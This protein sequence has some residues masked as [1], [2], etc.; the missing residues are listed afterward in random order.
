MRGKL[1]VNVV[2][3]AVLVVVI[4]AVSLV[5]FGG[6]VTSVFN[7]NDYSPIY[8]G[9][10]ENCVSLMVNVYWGN[11]YLEEML[12]ILAKHNVKCTFFVGGSWVAKYPEMLKAIAD[13]GHE[14]GNHGYFHKEHSKL[15]YLKNSDEILACNRVVFSQIGVTPV[16]FMPPSG[17]F[18]D[19]T[20]QAAKDCNMKMIMWSRDTIDWRDKNESIIFERCTKNIRSG[21]L[22]LMHPTLCTKNVLEKVITNLKSNGFSLVTVGQNIS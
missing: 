14:I 7:K 20:L 5:V 11:E 22:I 18:G 16:L 21:E 13:G 10:G 4:L 8:R 2:A 3:N 9:N 6:G 19:N 17:D 1:F 15:T 12:Q